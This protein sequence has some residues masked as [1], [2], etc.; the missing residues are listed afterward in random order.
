MKKI[1]FKENEKAALTRLKTVL[2]E[3]FK[4]LDFR[5]YGSKARG[6]ASTDSDIDVMVKLEKYTPEIESAIDNLVFDVNLAHD[7]FISVVIYSRKELEEGPL[8]ESPLYKVIEK[9]GIAI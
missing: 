3:R 7:C 2:S 5:V 4:L 8:G 1:V 6:E 9:E